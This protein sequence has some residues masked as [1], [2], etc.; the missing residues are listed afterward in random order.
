MS[1][2]SRPRPIATNPT[3]ELARQRNRAA[4]E[5]TLLAWI[6]SSLTL[7]GIGITLDYLILRERP[8][9]LPLFNA[10][11]LIA[12]LGLCLLGLA[13]WQ[14]WLSVRAVHSRSSGLS[15]QLMGPVAAV[16]VALFGIVA[17]VVVLFRSV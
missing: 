8:A 9:T 3:T 4:A 13:T 15:S 12:P 16:T 2:N 14:Y 11:L 10:G 5:R 17:A 7:L 6:Q 1:K